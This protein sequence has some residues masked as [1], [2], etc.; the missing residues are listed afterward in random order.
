METLRRSK[1]WQ[2][3]R[4]CP[5]LGFY[6]MNLWMASWQSDDAGTLEN[7][8]D[9]LCHL[10]ECD[11]D[12]WPDVRDRVL[13]GWT[14]EGK[15]LRHPF[16]TM[17]AEEAIDLDRRRA[18]R[19]RQRNRRDKGA[20][21]RDID[22]GE[23]DIQPGK[24]DISGNVAKSHGNRTRQDRTMTDSPIGESESTATDLTLFGEE[25][26]GKPVYLDPAFDLP[27][28]WLD[29]AMIKGRLSSEEVALEWEGFRAYWLEMTGKPKG[30]KR[31]W[32][33]TWINY[34]TSDICQKRVGARRRNSPSASGGNDGRSSSLVARTAE[35]YR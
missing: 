1:A 7:D 22:S 24:R 11:P 34:V 13:D 31:D 10:A 30:K 4:R 12:E 26:S 25:S 17:I 18:D 8:D 19:R 27:Q 5:A 32:K 6:M 29:E 15:A 14:V 2:R 35:R 16:V 20:D 28:G 23:R 21:E 3:A 33:R 9:L